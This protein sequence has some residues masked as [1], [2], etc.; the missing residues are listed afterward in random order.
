M[1]AKSLVTMTLLGA[2]SAVSLA[3]EYWLEIGG[4]S[5]VA[6][7]ILR[8]NIQLG[9]RFQGETVIRDSSRIDRFIVAQPDGKVVDVPGRDGSQTIGLIRPA[10]PGAHVVGLQTTPTGLTLDARAFESYL[11]EDGLEHAI[12]TRKARSMSDADGR[13]RY[14]RCAKSILDAEGSMAGFDRRVGMPLEITP[15]DDPNSP[16]GTVRFVVE[17]RDEPVEGVLITAA[18]RESRGAWVHGRTDA[19]GEVSFELGASGFWLV[20]GVHMIEDESPDSDWRS[21][22]ASLTFWRSGS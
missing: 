4:P 7:Q 11:A 21:Y 6:G 10:G 14:S 5:P 20:S 8:A 12:K 9:E 2:M 3:H 17:F 1:N 13:E 19:K 16:D 22:W 15:L 18:S